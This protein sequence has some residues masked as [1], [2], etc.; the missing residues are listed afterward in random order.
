MIASRLVSTR[1]RKDERFPYT[2]IYD[3]TWD[4]EGDSGVWVRPPGGGEP[5]LIEYSVR[6]P[7]LDSDPDDDDWVG[8]RYSPIGYY[9][10]PGGD[11]EAGVA[12]LLSSYDDVVTGDAARRA[13]AQLIQLRRTGK[14]VSYVG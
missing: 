7:D 14:Q 8:N 12:L 11:L 9:D 4:S 3:F 10:L 5:V 1:K 2:A 6:E 13:W